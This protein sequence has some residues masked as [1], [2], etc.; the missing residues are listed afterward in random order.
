MT[1][2]RVDPVAGGQRTNALAS[3]LQSRR[4]LL[5][6]AVCFVMAGVIVA[7]A[8]TFMPWLQ[9]IFRKYNTFNGW[10]L[11]ATDVFSPSRGTG[12]HWT[13][14][15]SWA[16]E[17]A[18]RAF[19]ALPVVAMCV[20]VIVCLVLIVALRQKK[21]TRWLT[22]V[23]WLPVVG[24]VLLCWF[25]LEN[26]DAW[27]GAIWQPKSGMSWLLVGGILTIIGGV[28]LVLAER[29]KRFATSTQTLGTEGADLTSA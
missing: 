23:S 25:A 12:V 26:K 27:D 28:F 1:D 20:V 3:W 24:G 29:A 14:T 7:V 2:N 11:V 13:V 5:V 16:D 21:A 9:D 17:P 19:T 18:R 15:Q 10:D 4:R 22:V 6:V 8:S